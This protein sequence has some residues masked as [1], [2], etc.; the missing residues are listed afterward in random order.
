MISAI[1]TL[2]GY[3]DSFNPSLGRGQ[4]RENRLERMKHLLS[5]IGS[6]EK[7]FQSIHIAGSK[8]KGSTAFFSARMLEKEGFKTGLYL[9]PHVYDIR[10][11]FTESGLF[12]PLSSYMN[13]L[14]ELDDKIKDFRNDRELGPE[15]PT[16]FE[17]YTAYAYLL[18]KREGMEYAMIETG[19]GGRLDAT[20]TL[21]PIASIITTI[22]LEH[23]EILGNTIEKIAS[24]KAGIIKNGIPFF[25]GNTADEATR[26][27]IA[28]CKEKETTATLFRD[29]YNDVRLV[30]ST[31]KA[32]NND[33]E[34]TIKLPYSS[35][36]EGED[37]LL[38]YMALKE[39]GLVH[40]YSYDLSDMKLPGRY[41]K[42]GRYIFDG[43]HTKES[44]E[45]LKKT[46]LQN[47]KLED[48]VLIFSAADGKDIDDMLKTL[49]PLFAHVIISKP[50]DFKPSKPAEIY[51]KAISLFPEK[52]I[53]L[54]EDGKKA[55]EAAEK[56]R[57][58]ILVTGSFYLVS[59]IRRALD[60]H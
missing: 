26:A 35:Y 31:I 12:F 2:S 54:I 33:T 25:G 9:S 24:E 23:T 14:D 16:T 40:G 20:N 42:D 59:K 36:K 5:H 21:S 3:F 19:L 11:R 1:D 18:F 15:K 44:A 46:I 52:D 39:L 38:G 37:A 49:I 34:I 41:E 56:S 51:R 17:L 58:I 60:E 30:D 10:E 45:E 53:I 4:L 13:T 28:K 32:T 55:I 47:E 22:E 7:S 50:E 29:Y 8:G 43:A 57:G 48:A 27:F 6:P